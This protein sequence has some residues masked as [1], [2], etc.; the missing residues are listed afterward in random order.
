MYTSNTD[1]SQQYAQ[2]TSVDQISCRAD[3]SEI[4]AGANTSH[5][6]TRANACH[7]AWRDSLRAAVK[8]L[9]RVLGSGQFTGEVGILSGRRTLFRVRATKPGRVIELDRQHMLALMQSDADWPDPDGCFHS[10]QG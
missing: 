5:Y 1:L 6:S 7:A 9:V 3:I 4:N 8:T 2:G 10:P